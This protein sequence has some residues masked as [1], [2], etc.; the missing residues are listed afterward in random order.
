[1][2]PSL[3]EPRTERLVMRAWC[4][5]DREPFAVMNADPEVMRYFPAHMTRAESDAF[6]D[7]IEGRFAVQ[8][9]GLW[10]LEVAATGEFVG[11]TGLNPMPAGVP[12]S[13][14]VEVGWR[15]ARSAW[16]HGYATEAGRTALEVAFGR[17]GLD[18]VWSL[19][20]EANAASRAVMS[21]LGLSHVATQEHPGL[22]ADSP[23]RLHVFYRITRQEYAGR[24]ATTAMSDRRVCSP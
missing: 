10:A 18:E 3:I 14:G 7:R 13:G 5:A 23:V 15:L 9:Y 16:G 20:A 1:M 8:G 22:A 6:V 17:L 11:F 19:T 2:P 21:R 4:G 12:G 24:A